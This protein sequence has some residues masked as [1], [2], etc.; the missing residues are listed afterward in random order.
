M[1]GLKSPGATVEFQ[2]RDDRGW[3]VEGDAS[4]DS[5]G[6]FQLWR[7][8]SGSPGWARIGRFPPHCQQR[9]RETDFPA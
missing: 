8:G 2:Q 1:P 5:L 9:P 3:S 7:L 6:P 4:R